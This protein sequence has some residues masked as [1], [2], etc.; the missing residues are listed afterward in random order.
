MSESIFKS[1]AKY[2]ANYRVPYPDETM[3]RLV[4]SCGL[5]GGQ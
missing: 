5:D 4:A 2:Y 3:A 1:T